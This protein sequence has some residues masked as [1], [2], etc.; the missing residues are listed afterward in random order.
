MRAEFSLS[1]ILGPDTCSQAD[2]LVTRESYITLLPPVKLVV[3]GASQSHASLYNADSGNSMAFVS[4]KFHGVRSQPIV[5][6]VKDFVIQN[7][8]LFL[9]TSNYRK[10]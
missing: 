6:S 9:P 7:D 4:A 5:Q 2:A 10:I 1:S 8:V 3:D